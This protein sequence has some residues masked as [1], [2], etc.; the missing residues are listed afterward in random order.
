MRWAGVCLAAAL[1][2]GACTPTPPSARGLDHDALDDAIAKAIGDPDTCVLLADRATRK[3]VYRYG[4]AMTCA[5]AL[6]AC[7]R[8]GTM[9]AADALA[10]AETP[11]GRTASCA[12]NPEVTRGVAWAEGKVDSK[13]HDLIFSAIMEGQRALPGIE[14]TT[15]LQNALADAGV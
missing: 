12:S 8:A 6:P 3:V 9:T 10:L 11:G 5:R 2:L 1:V 4:E 13:K 15:R 14:I 7:G